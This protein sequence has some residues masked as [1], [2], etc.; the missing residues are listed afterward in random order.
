MK[1][2][3]YTCILSLIVVVLLTACKSTQNNSSLASPI[4]LHYETSSI[5]PDF[6]AHWVRS[7]LIL[8]AND[9]TDP[10]LVFSK[11]GHIDDRNL[12]DTLY[13]I[14]AIKTPNWVSSSYP[15]L[16]HFY[17]YKVDIP[18]AEIKALLKQQM[19][20]VNIDNRKTS[21][22]INISG[23][24]YV[25]NAKLLD[26]LYTTK[27]NDGDE[28]DNLGAQI[29][30]DTT[31]FTLW[32]PTALDVKVHLFDKHKNPLES[33]IVSLSEDPNTGA[34]TGVTRDAPQGT[35]YRYHVQVYHPQSKQ[36]EILQVTDPYSLSLSTNSLYSQVVDLASS[37][38][39][40]QN[41][42]QHTIPEVDSPESLV[43]YETHIRDFS[44]SDNSLSDPAY[45]G[46]Y[47][48]FS[49]NNSDSILHL[50][51]LKKA[52]LNTIHLL[53]TYDL[54]TVEEMPGKAIS[55]QDTL[56][57]VCSI[58]NKADICQTQFDPQQSLAS[59]LSS[60][61]PLSADA[62]NLVQQIRSKDA[63]NW[64][65]DPYHYTVPEGSYALTP[66]GIARL[67]EF[68]QM[69][70]SQHQLGFR[71]IMDVVY[72]HT[73]AAGLAEKSVLDKIVPNY[74][75]RLDPISGAIEQ[76]T[77]CENSATE[78]AMMAK[79][80]T[81]S[82]VMWAQHYKIDGFRFDLMGHQPKQAMLQ[83]R[84]AVRAVDADTYFYGE[85]WNF[86]EVANN[87]QF[88]QASQMEMAGTEIGTF[89]DR[90]RDAVR[91]GSSFLSGSD[92]RKGQG[93]GNGLMVF[94]NELQS[95]L[96]AQALH[97]EYQLSMDQARIGLAANL[98]KFPLQNAKGEDVLGA[99]IDYGGAPSGYALDPADTINYVSKHD[100]QT[101]W[102]NNQY[103]I[104][105]Q[106]TTHERVR[107][108][109]ISLAYPLMAQG[110]PFIHMGSELLR[111]KSF[112]RDSYDFGDWFNKVDFGKN[113]NNYNVGLP[114]AEKDQSNWQLITETI[115]RNQ[116]RDLAS[117]EDIEFSSQ[118]FMDFLKVRTST[119][120]FSLQTADE[121]IQ[122]VKFLNTGPNQQKGV[123]VMSI[124]SANSET[125][126][127][128][129]KQVIVIFNH[130]PHT[131]GYSMAQAQ[132]FNL[133]P[134][135]QAG[136][137]PIVKAAT[138]DEF[139][140]HVPGLTVAVFVR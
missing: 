125:I 121:V 116:G 122:Q 138:T 16:R 57:K 49:E 94:P 76:S 43:L 46:K 69:V 25:Q 1:P 133:H 93:L 79:L 90:L 14:T 39:Q 15:H 83:A 113:A 35:F 40:P 95:Q 85:G 134:V 72:N 124:S 110:I 41:W 7:D 108:Q 21:D 17:A 107:M 135:Q 137:D 100:N 53:P 103:R 23:L 77:C 71:V 33:S 29:L 2:N 74:Y 66:E 130:N 84:E 89:T 91:G 78:N 127:S 12:A 75:H 51:A 106:A 88:T 97:E 45:A 36:I 117:P 31:R 128:N 98:A 34:W 109:L 52:G 47:A 123:I 81:D 129:F 9:Y 26:S 140:F 132:Q 70:M 67:V 10:A 19:A 119:K 50:K 6:A 60:Y 105:H 61:D 44:A 8:V 48:A 111:S 58:A 37:Q 30:A 99:H 82:L 5:Q 18:E 38:T 101:L 22:G 87:A 126:D 96:D 62:Q 63:Y 102:D 32:A 54:S 114:P 80:M 86:G 20:V 55:M 104:N 27:P 59:L 65:Y 64:G 92:I 4:K 136:S 56:D 73:F 13:H 28:I 131:I 118:V 120:L 24:S 115:T 68:R 3:F 42:L 112:L 11:N 139:G